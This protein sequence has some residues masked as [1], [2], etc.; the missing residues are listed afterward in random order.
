MKR[1]GAESRDRGKRCQFPRSEE[2][3]AQAKG[4]QRRALHFV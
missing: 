2:I 3:S 1:L 4:L